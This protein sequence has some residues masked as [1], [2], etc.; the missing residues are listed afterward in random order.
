MGAAPQL[1][2][3]RARRH[4]P[5]CRVQAPPRRWRHD[6]ALARLA[7]RCAGPEHQTRGPPAGWRQRREQARAQRGAT[8]TATVDTADTAATAATTPLHRPAGQRLDPVA[9]AA[10]ATLAVRAPRDAPHLN[11]SARTRGGAPGAAPAPLGTARRA[12][13][14]RW[15]KARQD[16]RQGAP[17]QGR[18]ERGGA[19][20]EGVGRC[21]RRPQK[22]GGT[23]PRGSARMERLT[24]CQRRSYAGQHEQGWD[25]RG[26][27]TSWES[28]P[29]VAVAA[30]RER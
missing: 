21:P 17:A 8:A 26:G 2:R 6:T 15:E 20:E 5:R 9:A 3:R 19:G 14:C 25:T 30:S 11:G 10:A 12:P 13:P 4:H 22:T 24:R 28:R 27:T 23:R 1:G 29:G 7:A 18:G 16:D